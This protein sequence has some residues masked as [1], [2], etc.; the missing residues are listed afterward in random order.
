MQCPVLISIVNG[1]QDELLLIKKALEEDVIPELR[2]W[3]YYVVNV[4]GLVAAFT[5]KVLLNSSLVV[6]S[7]FAS[8]LACCN[9]LTP[10]SDCKS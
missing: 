2:L 8:R 7:Q 5:D 10:C 1:A 9:D 6:A 3:E 4:S